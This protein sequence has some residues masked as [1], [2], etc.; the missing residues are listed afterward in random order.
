LSDNGL[1]IK[2]KISF[3]DHY[4]FSKLEIKKIVDKCLK[5]N[6]EIITTEKDYFR[7]KDYGFKNIKF[8][9]LKLEI[10]KKDKL[11]NQILSLL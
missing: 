5:D 10:I 3:P 1:N 11:I 6:F 7:I 4:K 9:K 2:E 8:L